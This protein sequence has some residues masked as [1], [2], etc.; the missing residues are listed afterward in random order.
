MNCSQDRGTH[1]SLKVSPFDPE[2]PT[3]AGQG[4]RTNGAATKTAFNC[5]GMSVAGTVMSFEGITFEDFNGSGNTIITSNGQTA[6]TQK[7]IDCIFQNM[8]QSIISN[9]AAASSGVPN[10]IDRCEIKSTTPDLFLGPGS[11]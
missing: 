2:S 7:F 11:H 9:P 10:L 8:D 6:P 5:S 3:F 1:V 4:A